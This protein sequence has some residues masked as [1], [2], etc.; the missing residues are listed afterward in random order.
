VALNDWKLIIHM[1]RK[2]ILTKYHCPTI[3]WG[4]IIKG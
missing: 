3:M 1:E 4:F 2:L